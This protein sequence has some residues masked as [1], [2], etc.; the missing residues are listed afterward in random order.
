MIW[1]S[2]LLYMNGNYAKEVILASISFTVS[3]EEKELIKKIA[4]ES[5]Y[6]TMSGY[7]AHLVVSATKAIDNARHGTQYEDVYPVKKE[8]NGDIRTEILV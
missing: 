4:S 7:C 8:E 5:A 3:D 1:I 6:K 2:A